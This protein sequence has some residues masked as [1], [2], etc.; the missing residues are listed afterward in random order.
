M[1]VLT[2]RA[3]SKVDALAN[4]PIFSLL[5]EGEREALATH[6]EVVK[7][8]EGQTMFSYGDP[9]DSM[10]VLL[11][12]AVEVFVKNK[13]GER[14]TLEHNGPGDF[15]GEISLLDAGPR[16]ASAVVV[17]AGEALLIDR[18]D[19]D[20]LFRV[21]PAAAMDLLSATGRRLRQTA[22]LLRNQ[23]TRNV[24]DAVED[25]RN[26]IMRIADGVA[27]F[28]GSIEFLLLHIVIFFTWIITNLKLLPFGDFDP[29]PFGLLTMV[30]SLEAIMLSTLLLFSSNRQAAHDKV[31]NDIEYEVNLKAEMQIQHLHE[32]LD[33]M[34]SEVLQRLS[35]LEKV[36]APE[37]GAPTSKV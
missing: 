11:S 20:E 10:Y 26:L 29:F 15:F 5:D 34:N 24:N 8:D 32:K 36:K 18:G 2:M 28:S 35:S 14:V 4:I 13:T 6:I 37:A 23:A 30:V 21:K 22:M 27:A 12:G 25:K 33:R 3:M 16:T 19:L 1:G 7:L 17:K 31:Q 9:G